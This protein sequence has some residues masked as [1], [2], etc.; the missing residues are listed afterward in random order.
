L[1]NARVL[2]VA[3]SLVLLSL[4]I[5]SALAINELAHHDVTSVCCWW[6]CCF[7]A[8]SESSSTSGTT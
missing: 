3:S 2:G 1:A 5:L 7:E 8:H 6:P 4:A